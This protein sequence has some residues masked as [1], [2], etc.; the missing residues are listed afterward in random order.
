MGCT[1]DSC[2]PTIRFT[3]LYWFHPPSV[4]RK[5]KT[6]F[7]T[8]ALISIPPVSSGAHLRTSASCFCVSNV[9]FQLV[10]PSA[11]NIYFDLIILKKKKKKNLTYIP[12]HYLF[13]HS[14]ASWKLYW[15][16]SPLPQVPFTLQSPVIWMALPPHPYTLSPK[17]LW[18]SNLLRLL[19]LNP[20]VMLFIVLFLFDP[21]AASA[22]AK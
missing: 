16:L 11:L 4:W 22:I 8:S 1:P 13:L 7:F 3:Q 15:S 19:L 18:Q 5:Q 9:S 14:Q 20:V 17:L 6:D 12:L 10:F 21:P 2:T